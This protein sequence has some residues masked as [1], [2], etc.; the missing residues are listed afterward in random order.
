M[1]ACSTSRRGIR[2]SRPTQTRC[3]L[4]RRRRDGTNAGVSGRS[5]FSRASQLTERQTRRTSDLNNDQAEKGQRMSAIERFVMR[6]G[7]FLFEKEVLVEVVV[8]RDV[9]VVSG[10]G[11]DCVFGLPERDHQEVR[12]VAFDSTEGICAFVAKG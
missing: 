9:D 6:R 12:G 11:A 2:R 10:E 3:F 1:R 5:D 8:F 7:R 4:L